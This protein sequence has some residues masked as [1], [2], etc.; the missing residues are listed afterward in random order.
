MKLL[1]INLLSSRLTLGMK[2]WL[3]LELFDFG[4][5]L[6]GALTPDNPILVFNATNFEITEKICSKKPEA[7]SSLLKRLQSKSLKLK[8]LR[9][10]TKKYIFRNTFYFFMRV[11]G[12][13]KDH[14]P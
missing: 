9:F 5:T 3:E 13:C 10:Q 2:I 1:F 8:N 4:K 14:R 11:G 7:I 6:Q 12:L